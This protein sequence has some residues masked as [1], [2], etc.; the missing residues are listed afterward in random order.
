[1]VTSLRSIV[2]AT[3]ALLL[4]SFPTLAQQ[5][6]PATDMAPPPPAASSPPAAAPAPGAGTTLEGAVQRLEKRVQQLGEAA[7]ETAQS[8]RSGGSTFVI[9]T[10]QMAMIAGGA[11]IGAIAADLVFHGGAVVLTGAVVGGLIGSWFYPPWAA[12]PGAS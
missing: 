12:T 1:M 11:L 7:R 3:A 8:L 2:F 9:T 4:T 6:G 5:A 10:D